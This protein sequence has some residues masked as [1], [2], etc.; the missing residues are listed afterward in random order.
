MISQ[1]NNNTKT[2]KFLCSNITETNV[3]KIILQDILINLILLVKF[4]LGKI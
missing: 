2:A 4:K 3:A 1:L